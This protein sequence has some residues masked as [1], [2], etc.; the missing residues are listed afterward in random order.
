MILGINLFFFNEKYVGG[1]NS[2][3]KGLING[4]IRNINKKE[5]IVI[6]TIHNITGINKNG[7]VKI[8]KIPKYYLYFFKLIKILTI[9]GN[10]KLI[11]FLISLFFFKIK[12]TIEDECDIFY[13]PISYLLPLNLKIK[14]ITSVHDIQFVHYPEYFSFYQR[15]VQN[16]MFKLTFNHSD[17]IQVNSKFIETDLIKNFK[18]P[19]NKM[20]FINQGV[21]PKRII[22][23]SN[24]I[25]KKLIFFPAQI[26]PHK[27]HFLVLETMKRLI[28]IDPQFKLIMVGE[29]FS[30][31]NLNEMIENFKLKKNVKYFGRVSL[32]NLNRLYN[33]ADIVLCPSLYESGS[34]PTLEAILINKN[35]ISS[36]IET[37]KELSNI[38]RIQLF[39]RNSPSNLLEVILD[40]YNNKKLIKDNID[41]NSKIIKQYDWINIAKKYYHEFKKL[42]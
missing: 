32:R 42:S 19:E 8:K 30:N 11:Y 35:V 39:K 20:I 10:I 4:L 15:K 31:I 25:I 24:K 36:D 5:K 33:L 13:C 28:E 26:W 22:K 21:D 2:F 34:L 17:N 40:T 9:F 41:Y 6:Y 27:N 7:Q 38:F 16:I 23:K 1:I 14:T 12:L 29:N 18:V 3:T 37:H